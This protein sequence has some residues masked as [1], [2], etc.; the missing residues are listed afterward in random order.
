MSFVR[1]GTNLGSGFADD[2]TLSGTAQNQWLAR[3]IDGWFH[4][5]CTKGLAVRKS[6]GCE[7]KAANTALIMNDNFTK[8]K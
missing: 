3:S 7:P 4:A 1:Y 8:S 5:A 2:R 6:G